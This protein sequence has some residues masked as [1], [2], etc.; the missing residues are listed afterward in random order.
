MIQGTVTADREAVIGLTIIDGS[1]QLHLVDVVIDTGYTGWLTL[2]PNFIAQ[3]G[4]PFKRFGRATLADGTEV[5]FSVYDANVIWDGQ[6]R[7][8]RV[9]AIE[10]KPLLG[11]SLMYGYKLTLEDVDG[12]A[13]TLELIAQP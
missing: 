6:L 2:P 8:I 10:A 13:V 1:G 11:M 4:L 12:G 9:D 3:W 7:S 5:A